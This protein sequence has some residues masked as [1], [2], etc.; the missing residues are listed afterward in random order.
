MKNQ[1]GDSNL[2]STAHRFY[3]HLTQVFPADKPL[4]V[5]LLRLMMALNDVRHVQKLM[6]AKDEWKGHDNGFEN[7]VLNGEILHL[8]RLLCSHLY[9][10]G[11][12]FR[13]I[14]TKHS[15]LANTAVRGTEYDPSLRR[16][17]EAY[18]SDPPDA[19]HSS[20]LKEVRDQFGFHEDL[21]G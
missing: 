19:F 7:V 18:A 13:A 20:F 4:S 15:K 8:E 3:F 16:L 14:D 9:E 17:R 1:S 12:A 21:P 6:L 2:Q 5:P 10:A 11:N